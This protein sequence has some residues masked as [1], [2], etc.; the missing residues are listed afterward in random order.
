MRNFKNKLLW[1]ALTRASVKK[2]IVVLESAR[3]E[4]KK[5][6]TKLNHV[7]LLALRNERERPNVNNVEERMRGVS[8]RLAETAGSLNGGALVGWT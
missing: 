7:L 3:K 5:S 2:N 8:C 6:I 4:S 1:G